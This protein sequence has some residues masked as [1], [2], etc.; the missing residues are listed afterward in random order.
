MCLM[1]IS[2]F[3]ESKQE[4]RNDISTEIVRYAASNT[5][6]SSYYIKVY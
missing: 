1:F 4:I 2:T 5:E 3:L 6:I